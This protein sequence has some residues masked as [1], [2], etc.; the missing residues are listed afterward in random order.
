MTS[1]DT[2]R[3]LEG[4]HPLTRESFMNGSTDL[5]LGIARVLDEYCGTGWRLHLEFPWP[6]P[7]EPGPDPDPWPIIGDR[8]PEPWRASAGAYVETAAQSARML[9]AVVASN[10]VLEAGSGQRM[11]EQFASDEG[12]QRFAAIHGLSVSP[13]GDGE[14][15]RGP[16]WKW[17][18]FARIAA[19]LFAA[20]LRTDDAG[21]ASAFHDAARRVADIAR[22]GRA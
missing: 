11:L 12:L 20:G 4:P 19:E 8:H 17:P 6:P 22:A 1:A 21:L 18:V 10:E 16:W 7:P 2:R 14:G 9:S 15:P 3:M 13:V 5:A